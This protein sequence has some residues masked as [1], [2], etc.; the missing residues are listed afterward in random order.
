[1]SLSWKCILGGAAG[2]VLSFF[3][4]SSTACLTCL[5]ACE[6]NTVQN[7][8]DSLCHL[9]KNGKGYLYVEGQSCV[10]SLNWLIINGCLK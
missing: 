6:L 8:T 10:I 7:K 5:R 3:V 2:T 4:A 1:M 9:H